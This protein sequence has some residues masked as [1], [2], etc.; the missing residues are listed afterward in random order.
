MNKIKHKP[1]VEKTLQSL[2]AR[3]GKVSKKE[4]K[5]I[6]KQINEIMFKEYVNYYGCFKRST[7]W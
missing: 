3:K 1:N 6:D 4:Q 2:Y 7:M 5:R